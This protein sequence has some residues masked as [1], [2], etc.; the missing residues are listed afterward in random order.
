MN[1]Q[2]R[3]SSI[4]LWSD[5]E[6]LCTGLLRQALVTLT[7]RSLDDNE[8]DLNRLLFRAINRISYE[9]TRRGELVPAVVYEGRNP[10][11]ASDVER[12]KRE[13]KIPDFYWAYIDP[14]ANDPNAAAVQFVVECKRL[15]SPRARY[16][17][18]YVK[19]GIVRFRSVS[20]GYGKGTGSGAMVGYLQALLI[21]DALSRINAINGGESIPPVTLRWRD[22]E[23][24]AELGH[25]IS[26][27]FPKSPFHLFHIWGR[28][29]PVPGI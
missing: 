12:A 18:E 13:S 27:S 6:R 22:G 23:N 5:H 21:R 16:T 14:H 19:S 29:G 28:V 20:H 1:R 10:P 11:A 26:R 15:T 7:D 2:P 24:R 9:A 8:D 4:D 17:R 25:D 3:L